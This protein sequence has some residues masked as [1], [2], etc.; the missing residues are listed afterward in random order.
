MTRFGWWRRTCVQR[1]S[2]SR[3]KVS[4]NLRRRGVQWLS[5]GEVT[6]PSCHDPSTARAGAQKTCAGGSRLALLAQRTKSSDS[7]LRPGAQKNVREEKQG[8]SVRERLF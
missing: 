6:L 4:K 1:R 2:Q 7:S 5:P 8:R 3:L